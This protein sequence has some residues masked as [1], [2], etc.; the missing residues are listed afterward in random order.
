MTKSPDAQSVPFDFLAFCFLGPH[1]L[2]GVQLGCGTATWAKYEIGPHEML[3]CRAGKRDH[4]MWNVVKHWDT[5]LKRYVQG[6]TERTLAVRTLND[7]CFVD[8]ET[9]S[10]WWGFY[11]SHAIKRPSYHQ[12]FGKNVVRREVVIRTYLTCKQNLEMRKSA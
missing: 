12:A 2:A 5:R 3:Q 4:H 10:D 6:R 11:M 9:G 7:A 1:W 8:I